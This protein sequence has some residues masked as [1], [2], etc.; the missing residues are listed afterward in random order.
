MVHKIPSKVS[1]LMQ[2]SKPRH[3]Q[4]FHSRVTL[5]S[6]CVQDFELKYTTPI[7][8]DWNE[9]PYPRPTA[10]LYGADKGGDSKTVWRNTWCSES[11]TGFQTEIKDFIEGRNLRFT[12]EVISNDEIKFTVE[13][14]DGSNQV[15]VGPCMTYF[16]RMTNEN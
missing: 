6:S 5:L 3:D 2:M 10:K 1:P 14:L 12:R 11:M 8:Q 16:K 15:V 9:C 13:V 4:I 7:N